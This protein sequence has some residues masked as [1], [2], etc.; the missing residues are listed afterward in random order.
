MH[1]V[2]EGDGLRYRRAAPDDAIDDR[3]TACEDGYGNDGRTNPT[4]F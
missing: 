1:G 4:H 2:V 3:D